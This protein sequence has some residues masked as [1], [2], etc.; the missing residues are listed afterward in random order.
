MVQ[1]LL[2][3]PVVLEAGKEPATATIV[4]QVEFS[5]LSDKPPHTSVVSEL[6]PELEVR[7]EELIQQLNLSLDHL[8]QDEQTECLLGYAN[9]FALTAAEL[10]NTDVTS[11]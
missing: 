5:E 10:G 11:Q 3:I 2:T 1:N 8:T 7:R 4:E 6:E 9:T